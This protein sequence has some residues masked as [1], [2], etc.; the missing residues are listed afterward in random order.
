MKKIGKKNISHLLIGCLGIV[1]KL[2]PPMHF[3]F[4][5]FGSPNKKSVIYYSK[6]E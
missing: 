4:Y 3:Y 1:N 5:I 6:N 2:S